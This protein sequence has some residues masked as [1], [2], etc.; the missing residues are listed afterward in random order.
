MVIKRMDESRKPSVFPSQ[1]N[2][3]CKNPDCDWE[4]D[5]RTMPYKGLSSILSCPKCG[6]TDFDKILKP[7]HSKLIPFDRKAPFEG[8]HKYTTSGPWRIY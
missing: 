8:E 4:G 5:W 6:G 7:E 3:L 1:N 2:N